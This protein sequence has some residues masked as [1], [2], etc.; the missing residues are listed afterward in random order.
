MVV[1]T[2]TPKLWRICQ[3]PAQELQSHQQGV[4][5]PSSLDFSTV[6]STTDGRTNK[7]SQV[8]ALLTENLRSREVDSTAAQG[9]LFE[10]PETYETQGR[11]Q[12]TT[13]RPVRGLRRRV[14]AEWRQFGGKTE[15]KFAREET[16]KG[17][18]LKSQT[19]TQVQDTN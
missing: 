8:E 5:V 1:D 16:N 17:L 3:A 14:D 2:V 19:Q 4:R 11:I 9:S 15:E 6:F 18:Q 10:W 13:T 12:S 7:P